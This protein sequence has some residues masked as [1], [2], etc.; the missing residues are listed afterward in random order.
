MRKNL[1]FDSSPRK[2]WMIGRA[3]PTGQMGPRGL[4]QM[5]AN[6]VSSSSFMLDFAYQMN[7]TIWFEPQTSGF[8]KVVPKVVL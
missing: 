7:V 5:I 1:K 4:S 2:S 6:E 8:P 3:T